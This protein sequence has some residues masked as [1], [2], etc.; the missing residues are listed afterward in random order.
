MRD[1]RED[2][3]QRKLGTVSRYFE[4]MSRFDEQLQKLHEA[5]RKL[6][7]D[8]KSEKGTIDAMLALE[9]NRPAHDIQD[10]GSQTT[11]ALL[12]NLSEII[13]QSPRD[14][15]QEQ[16]DAEREREPSFLQTSAKP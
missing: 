16:Q 10:T 11:S 4:A 2:L 15:F 12:R 9:N 6:M 3:L 8:I 14:R 1:I 5:H 7:T 13:Q